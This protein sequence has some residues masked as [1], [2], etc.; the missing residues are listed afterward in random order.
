MLEQFL[1][2]EK[3]FYRDYFPLWL[4]TLIGPWILTF[5]LLALIYVPLLAGVFG[6]TPLGLREWGVLALFPFV[7]LGLEEGRKWFVR[8]TVTA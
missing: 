3:N 6:L 7:I 4:G 1:E 2:F 5:V 8:R